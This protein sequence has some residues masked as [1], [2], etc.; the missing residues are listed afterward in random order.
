MG[1]V[2][3]SSPTA[4]MSGRPASSSASTREPRCCDAAHEAASEV[5]AAGNGVEPD[6]GFDVAVDPVVRLG[7]E[8]RAGRADRTQ[9]R[10]VEIAPGLDAGLQAIGEERRAGAKEGHARILC[11]APQRIE[12]GRAGVAV[13]DG[14]R[15]AAE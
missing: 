1:A 8:R 7:R 6:V 3:T 15:D 11:E 10:Q 12:I 5:G 9:S 14:E 13:V 2:Q 4:S